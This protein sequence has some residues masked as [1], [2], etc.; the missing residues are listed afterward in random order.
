MHKSF[1]KKRII[2]GVIVRDGIAVQSIGFKTYL[3]LGDPK[4]IC[5][6]YSRWG[7]DEIFLNCI[8][9]SIN[10]KGPD[11]KS[12][13]EVANYNINSPLIYAGGIRNLNDAIKCIKL[14]ADRII[15]DYLK[16]HNFNEIE[17]I[18]KTLGRQA[19][20]IS[21]PII[22]KNKR[23]F[24]YNYID[25]SLK[26]MSFLN[27]IA[28]KNIASEL[29]IIDFKNNGGNFNIKNSFLNKINYFKSCKFIFYGG[30]S[31][32]SDI[33]KLLN[34]KSISAVVVGNKLSYT[35]HSYQKIK[36][37]LPKSLIRIYE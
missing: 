34:N 12:L 14:G 4:I 5:E 32:K 11:Y 2:A 6:N 27:D 19:I 36:L 8:D 21:L 23:Y 13:E 9:R 17:K 31:K 20:I 25:K 15:I 28:S 18:S 26:E 29:L 35:E 7:A 30:I 16:Y 33:N 3:P 37:G 1:L 24:F 22:Y 10:N